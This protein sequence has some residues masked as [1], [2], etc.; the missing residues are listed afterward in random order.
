MA[1][2]C[3]VTSCRQSAKLQEVLWWA[4]DVQ[5]EV[6]QGVTKDYLGRPSHD[7]FAFN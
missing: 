4:S 5:V 1:K 3:W 7:T 6:C 2:T